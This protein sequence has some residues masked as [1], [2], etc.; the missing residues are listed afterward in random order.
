[1]TIT[2]AKNQ[3]MQRWYRNREHWLLLV[4][5]F[6]RSGKGSGTLISQIEPSTE[7]AFHTRIHID[8][9]EV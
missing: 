9:E 8:E 5:E 2:V 7:V 6:N 3:K 4:D 1:M